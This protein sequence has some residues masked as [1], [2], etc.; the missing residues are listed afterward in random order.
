MISTA[1][2]GGDKNGDQTRSLKNSHLILFRE[3]ERG[4]AERHATA[5]AAR[6][7]KASTLVRDVLKI[8]IPF[9]LKRVGIMISRASLGAVSLC[10][11]GEVE[12]TPTF[13]ADILK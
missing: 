11:S 6:A 13:P 8:I 9:V 3:V 5:G 10:H 1:G 2:N 4:G 12:L 7:I